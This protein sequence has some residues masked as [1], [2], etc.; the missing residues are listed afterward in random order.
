MSLK[1]W[2][3][4]SVDSYSLTIHRYTGYP[5]WLTMT[6]LQRQGRPGLYIRALLSSWIGNLIGAVFGAVMFSYLTQALAEEPYRSGLIDQLIKDVIASQWHVIFLKAIACGH[7]VTLAMFF[8]TQNHDG[9]SKAIGLHLP[10]FMSTT[11]RFPH[12][13]E[14]MYLGSIG[15]MLGAPISIGAFLWKCLLPDTL[16]NA[17]SGALFVGAYNWW[18]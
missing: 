14:Y 13:V 18:A 2:L 10:F 4:S 1:P 12:T 8:G 3:P 11:A 6:A 7:L 9:V 17:V 5:M 15:M 16:G